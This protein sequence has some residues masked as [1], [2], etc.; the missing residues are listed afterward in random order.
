M[1]TPQPHER[2]NVIKPPCYVD[3]LGRGSRRKRSVDSQVILGS[4][5]ARE[6]LMQRKFSA[7]VTTVVQ[8]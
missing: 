8:T 2:I 1:D 6:R 3:I 5:V 4:L 7:K